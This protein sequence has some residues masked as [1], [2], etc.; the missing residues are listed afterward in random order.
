MDLK[1]RCRVSFPRAAVA[2]K[3][4]GSAA[5][6][7]VNRSKN[8]H[9][10]KDESDKETFRLSVA[11]KALDQSTSDRTG[12]AGYR[13]DARESKSDKKTPSRYSAAL[14]PLDL[15]LSDRT[16]NLDLSDWSGCR[17]LP[18]NVVR[19]SSFPVSAALAIKGC[20]KVQ[21]QRESLAMIMP[22]P[23]SSAPQTT[24]KATVVLPDSV[25]IRQYHRA[26]S[27][28]PS[29]SSG[30]PIGIGWRYDSE[31]TIRFDIDEYERCREGLRRTKKEMV[32][33]PD[34]REEMLREAGYSHR[35][36]F[37]AMQ[38]AKKERAKRAASI[39]PKRVQ[40]VMMRIIP[41]R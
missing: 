33:P 6:D 30:A 36:I 16:A 28:N 32:I 7:D 21:T 20:L 27:D 41:R 3:S 24:D 4:V 5:L 37:L 26:L 31:D 29:T 39:R 22:T 19:D 12:W 18:A 10:K 11:L 2:Q 15:S 14:R 8:M 9:A 13:E 23:P 1:N 38:V 25:E 34:V 40:N 17:R 35:E